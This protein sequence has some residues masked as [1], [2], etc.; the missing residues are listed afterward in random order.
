MSVHSLAVHMMD[1][2]SALVLVLGVLPPALTGFGYHWAS[3]YNPPIYE[4]LELF[5]II[6]AIVAIYSSW[7]IMINP[8]SMHW[9]FFTAITLAVIVLGVY[10]GFPAKYSIGPIGIHSVN[11]D[12]FVLRGR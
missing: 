11:L 4:H 2:A 12:T 8:A 5:L 10:L 7:T 1:N 9:I 6:P 3:L